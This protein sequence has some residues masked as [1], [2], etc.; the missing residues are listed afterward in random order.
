MLVADIKRRPVLA[1]TARSVELRSALG[2]VKAPPED[3][4]ART[5]PLKSPARKKREQVTE[6][7]NNRPCG[8]KCAT[9]GERAAT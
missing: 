7:F 3:A 2:K 1:A 4:A 5:L 6:A 8:Q 9:V